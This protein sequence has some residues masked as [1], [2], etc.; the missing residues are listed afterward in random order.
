MT[1]GDVDQQWIKVS[2]ANQQVQWFRQNRQKCDII[3]KLKEPQGAAAINF[4]SEKRPGYRLDRKFRPFSCH[5]T[6][7]NFPY[8]CV[9]AFLNSI[10]PFFRFQHPGMNLGLSFYQIY[11]NQA[12]TSIGCGSRTDWMMRSI[13]IYRILITTGQK[14]DCP[15]FST[16]KSSL[17]FLKLK[18]ER[19]WRVWNRRD[20]LPFRFFSQ[21]RRQGKKIRKWPSWQQYLKLLQ[22]RIT[23]IHLSISITYNWPLSS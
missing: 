12:P 9:L 14:E 4:F 5:K 11:P 21:K 17:R 6:Q 2:K 22:E 1:F 7:N 3:G 8:E 23:H 13:S 10:H 18:T 19:L 15:K 20:D 16:P